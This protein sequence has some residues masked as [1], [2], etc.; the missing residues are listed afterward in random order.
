MAKI[1]GREVYPGNKIPWF[2]AEGSFPMK[3]SIAGSRLAGAF[4]LSVGAIWIYFFIDDLFKALKPTVI[5]PELLMMALIILPGIFV[6]IYGISQYVYREETIIDRKSVLWR[7]PGLSGSR[8]WRELISNYQ[9]VLK[10][11][12]YP[13]SIRLHEKIGFELIDRKQAFLILR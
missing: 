1:V 11:H 9:G 3:Y 7:R 12:Q 8:E 6:L 5:L 2:P 4:A 10:E 13:A